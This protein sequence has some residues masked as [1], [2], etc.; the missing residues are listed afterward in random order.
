MLL[1]QHT[2][3][4]GVAVGDALTYSNVIYVNSWLLSCFKKVLAH[5]RAGSLAPPRVARCWRIDTTPR[6]RDRC[7]AKMAAHSPSV[8]HVE[9]RTRGL[10]G[11]V[12][13]CQSCCWDEVCRYRCCCC[14]LV[15]VSVNLS[16]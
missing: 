11:E 6:P 4:C 5:A 14:R 15:S 7:V 10:R 16:S 12:S 3:R 1:Q 8:E 13:T 9:Q 2:Y